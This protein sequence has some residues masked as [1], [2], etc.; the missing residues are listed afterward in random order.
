MGV[1]L[2]VAMEGEKRFSFIYFDG[3]PFFRHMA[4]SYK[5]KLEHK[6]KE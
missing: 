5:F 2:V 1:N 3:I 6:S 4:F